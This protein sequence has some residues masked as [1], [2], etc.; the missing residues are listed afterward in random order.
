MTGIEINDQYI[1]ETIRKV[2]PFDK[3]SIMNIALNFAKKA[4]R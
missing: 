4:L 3:S 2:D 1:I